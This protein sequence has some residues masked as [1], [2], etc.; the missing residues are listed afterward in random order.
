VSRSTV[1]GPCSLSPSSFQ[2]HDTALFALCANNTMASKLGHS[3]DLNGPL[4]FEPEIPARNSKF[5]N[6][7]SAKRNCHDARIAANSLSVKDGVCSICRDIFSD[8]HWRIPQSLIEPVDFPYHGS[9]AFAKLLRHGQAV[10]YADCSA[11][12]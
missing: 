11:R 9:N 7:D 8:E 1:A 4:E 3:P 2:P 12:R 6:V 5:Y 10:V